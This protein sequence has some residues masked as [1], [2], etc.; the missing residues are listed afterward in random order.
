[1]SASA[2]VA[3]G[4]RS[5]SGWAALVALAGPPASPTV[6]DRRRIELADA[7]VEGSKQ[8][9]HEAEGKKPKEAERIVTRCIE[10][11]RLLA[12]Q[13]LRDVVA[14]LRRRDHEVA[15]CGL[16]L[17]SGRALPEDVHAILASHALIHAAE[18]EMYRDVLVRASEHLALRVT[19]VRERD[20][21]ARAAE[22]ASRPAAELQRRVAEMG[23]TLGPP[24]RQDEKLAALAA[25]VVLAAH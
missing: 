25:W 3:L 18:G 11:S 9:Y 19:G 17:A 12:R 21:L 2:R 10:S 8:P 20:V 24:W 23:R 5:H 15:G 4:L 13:A 7:T 22:A 6:V 14:D 16:L 1:V